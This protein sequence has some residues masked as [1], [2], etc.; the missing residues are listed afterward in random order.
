MAE[1][2]L[3]PLGQGGTNIPLKLH[4]QGSINRNRLLIN[5]N[6]SN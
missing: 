1:M 6:V 3:A 4:T 5:G 2:A